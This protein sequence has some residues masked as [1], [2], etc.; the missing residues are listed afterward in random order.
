[1]I[2]NSII[3]H[4]EEQQEKDSLKILDGLSRLRQIANHPRM[5]DEDYQADSGKFMEILDYLENLISEE[6]KVLVFSSY[7]K[8]LRLLEEHF[9][10]IGW[11]YSLLTGETH[12][13]QK[14]IQEFQDQP[15]NQIFLIQIKAG[16]F[17]LNLTAA[18]YVLILD[19]WWN[20]AV[21]EQAINRAHRIG[22]EKKVNVYRFISAGTVEEKIQRLQNKK[23]RLAETFITPSETLKKLSKEQLL[24]LFG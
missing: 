15:D 12:N 13:R 21:E 20:P 9:Q 18:D 19:P 1:M 2:R 14:V 16:G 24:E 23:A 17:G 11:Q 5:V 10:D 3:E 22:Q 8:H 4:L 7:K 6:H